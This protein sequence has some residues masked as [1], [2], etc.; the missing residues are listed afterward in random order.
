M[1]W[2]GALLVLGVA[3]ASPGQPDAHAVLRALS[4]AER[5]AWQ[6]SIMKQGIIQ[7]LQDAI[8]R[9]SDGGHCRRPFVTLTYAQV[10][11][12]CRS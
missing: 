8:T 7:E 5:A 10:A 4:T 9:H 6:A 3:F 11:C 12:R 2:E 1:R